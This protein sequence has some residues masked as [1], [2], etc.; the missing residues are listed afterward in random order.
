MSPMS[1]ALEVILAILLIA[2]LFYC[3]RLDRKL[4]ALRNSEQGL[5]AAAADLNK[6]IQQAEIS[7]KS[8]RLAAQEN[9]RDGGARGETAKAL[10][11]RASAGAALGDRFR[12]T[13]R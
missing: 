9:A 10:D 1:I 7:I 11:A 3:W 12:R 8:L 2:C 5:R 6:A 13:S 4:S